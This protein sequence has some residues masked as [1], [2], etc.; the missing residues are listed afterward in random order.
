MRYAPNSRIVRTGLAF[1]LAALAACGAAETPEQTFPAAPSTAAAVL[2]ETDISAE[3]ETAVPAETA[4]VAETY[5]PSSVPLLYEQETAAGN[6]QTLGDGDGNDASLLFGECG[7]AV[8]FDMLALAGNLDGM[9]DN[10]AV[11]M[12]WPDESMTAC[13]SAEE[14]L[15]VTNEMGE[16]P[17]G[18]LTEF[19]INA[20]QA[21]LYY[22]CAEA[23]EQLPACTGVSAEGICLGYYTA[24]LVD[25]TG[26][27]IEDGVMPDSPENQAAVLEKAAVGFERCG[28]PVLWDS[29]VAALHPGGSEGGLFPSDALPYTRSLCA[30][31]RFASDICP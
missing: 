30:D 29:A 25:I 19:D 8:L 4:A 1:A 23:V 21:S 3:S 15:A 12:G 14:W 9:S 13:S 26:D 17:D 20:L 31:E 27:L 10:P 22:Q 7:L 6:G 11:I 18:E 2:A 16:D 28:D 24:V 5:A